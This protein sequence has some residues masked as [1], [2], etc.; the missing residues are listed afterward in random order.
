MSHE[1]V[2]V[3]TLSRVE[4]KGGGVWAEE[5]FLLGLTSGDSKNISQADYWI[6]GV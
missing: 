3:V 1:L 5:T 6:E 2:K 4:V